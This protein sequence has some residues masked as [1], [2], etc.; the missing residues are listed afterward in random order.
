MTVTALKL[1]SCIGGRFDLSIIDFVLQR[2]C[3]SESSTR[4]LLASEGVDQQPIEE[5]MWPA[6]EEGLLE[7][8]HI[9]SMSFSATV[10]YKFAHDKVN[11]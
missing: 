6:V 3:Q 4:T 7:E 8:V 11:T 1:A 9:D 5:I 2:W 10:H